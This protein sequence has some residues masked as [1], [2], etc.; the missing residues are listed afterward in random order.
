MSALALLSS[1]DQLLR[2][3]VGVWPR[4]AAL[5]L[6]LS[7]EQGLREYFQRV[8]PEL[9]TCTMLERML[10]LE[11]YAGPGLARQCATLWSGLSQACHYHAYELSPTPGELRRW[12]EEVAAV[13]SL[14][15]SS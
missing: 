3:S 14:L 12:R 1:A 11:A 9:N 5:L 10:C 6:R 13:L 2:T 7:L 15:G 4:P 8:R